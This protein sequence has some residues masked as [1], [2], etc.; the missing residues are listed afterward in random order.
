MDSFKAFWARMFRNPTFQFGMAVLVIFVLIMAVIGKAD[1][2]DLSNA[3]PCRAI[4]GADLP[5]TLRISYAELGDSPTYLPS[6]YLIW[7][8]DGS[9]FWVRRSIGGTME[10]VE[11]HIPAGQ[12]IVL[13]APRAYQISSVWTH[14]FEFGGTVTD[15]VFVLPLDR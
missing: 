13:P 15:S 9:E 1:A 6:A 3:R 11:I 4:P 8:G 10:P 12:S 7:T 2:A 14:V 5:D